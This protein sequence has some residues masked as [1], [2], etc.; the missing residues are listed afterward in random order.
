MVRTRS[1]LGYE[2]QPEDVANIVSFLL[3]DASRYITGQT[4]SEF[5]YT[6]C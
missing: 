6:K 1:A 4:V 5:L 3:S 2:G